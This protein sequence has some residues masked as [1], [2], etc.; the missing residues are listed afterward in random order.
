MTQQVKMPEPVAYAIFAENGNIR[1]WSSVPG[2]MPDLDSL[3]PMHQLITTDQAEAY[4]DA[5]V[6][7]ALGWQPIETAPKDGSTILAWEI[8]PVYDESGCRIVDRAKRCAIVHWFFGDWA[9]YPMNM[10]RPQGQHFTH[11][12]PLPPPPQHDNE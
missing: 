1:M 6:R 8:T 11:W 5:C 9:G 4:K 3:G 10:S 12:M 7:E 2:D